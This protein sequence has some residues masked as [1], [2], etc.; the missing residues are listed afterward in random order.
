[1]AVKNRIK[2]G[3]GDPRHGTINGY[4]NH[5]CRCELCRAAHTEQHF[6]YMQNNPEQQEKH[7]RRE[8]EAYHDGRRKK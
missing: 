2:A 5:A 3:D 6:Q 7:A 4:T 1:M 8:N